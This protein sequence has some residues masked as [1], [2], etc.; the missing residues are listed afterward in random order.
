MKLHTRTVNYLAQ[1]RLV[2]AGLPPLLARL[3]AARGIT[4]FDDARL[5]LTGMLAPN[6]LKG[7]DAAARLLSDTI[8][9][10]EPIVVV[11]DY[12]CDGATAIAVAVLGLRAM[13]ARVDYLVPNRFE[14]GYG[15]TPEV[16]DL[17]A[18][19]PRLGRPALLVT[20]DN[21]IASV[22]GVDRA[23]ELG[24][25]VLVTDH[26]LPGAQL[27]S[28][29]V[30]V[31]PNQADC[32]FPSKCIAGVGVIFYLLTALRAHRRELGRFEGREPSLG[33]LLDLVALGT[34]ADVVP[35]DRNNRILVSAGLRRMRAGC[36]RPGISALLQVAR[37]S[38]RSISAADLGFA[39]GP[40]LNAAGRLSDMSIGVECLLAEDF[41][42]A[43]ELAEQLDGINSERRAIEE[44][45]REQAVN[46]LCDVKPDRLALVVHDAG[47]HHGVIGLVA[48]RIKDL[49]HRPCIALAPEN[50]EILRG[51][52]RSIPG[53]HLR[54]VLDLVEKRNPGMLLKF[55][56]HAMAA[57]LS[58][59]RR[60]L[61]AF[62]AAFED[63]VAKLADPESFSPSLITDGPLE[64]AEMSLE[65]I[66]QIDSQ[67]WG[68]GFAQ[69]L[70][71][72]RFTILSQRLIK[73]RHMKL[74]LAPESEPRQRLKAIFFGRAQALPRQAV[75][76]YRLQREEYQGLAGVCLQVEHVLSE[77]TAPAA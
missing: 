57:G 37:R 41:G 20:V 21:G 15:L 3:L 62:E 43:L 2:Q 73:D 70:F 7:M 44:T 29:E 28:A 9:R 47:W 58:M 76:A 4:C 65:I 18:A 6:L 32:R 23:H 26:H 19:H 46:L 8:D 38:A 71:S 11:G 5:E 40:R 48:S 66:E 69:P 25:K 63:A 74:E 72:G 54:D 52:G 50:E 77:L 64:G 31:N 67:I 22:T 56:G 30:I 36:C 12:D 14:N 49:H 35:L 13:G 51:S 61:A 1:Q 53:V 55:G 10:N 60:D 16:A 33:P 68:Q 59:R 17:A 42:R 24:M 27:P 39:I 45:M 34:V 75:L